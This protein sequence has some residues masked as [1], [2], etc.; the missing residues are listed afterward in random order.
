[1]D[2]LK[3]PVFTGGKSFETI[4]IRVAQTPKW[5]QGAHTYG[6]RQKCISDE[7]GGGQ[8]NGMPWDGTSPIT[9]G[10][11]IDST[12][13]APIP[14]SDPNSPIWAWDL[15]K[16]WAMAQNPFF[17][18]GWLGLSTK[19]EEAAAQVVDPEF[20]GELSLLAGVAYQ[21]YLDA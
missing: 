12:R 11:V 13:P 16:S 14:R 4:T 21:R 3:N 1:M 8:T 19:L 10:T 18:M 20:S 7:P 17:Q 15:E 2:W 9:V 6:R 5:A